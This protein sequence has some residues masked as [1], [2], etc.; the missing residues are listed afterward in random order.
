MSIIIVHNVHIVSPVDKYVK[1]LLASCTDNDSETS[2]HHHD[3]VCMC[4]INQN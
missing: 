2:K 4:S 3:H 1:R